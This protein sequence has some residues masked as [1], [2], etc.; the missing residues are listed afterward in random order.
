MPIPHYGVLAGRIFDRILATSHD[1]HYHM[2]VNRG[3][4]PQ[5][6][7]INTQS[8]TP[9]SQVLYYANTDLPLPPVVSET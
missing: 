4:T 3:D 6:V 8:S 2:L 9:P 7:A 1:E 5:R